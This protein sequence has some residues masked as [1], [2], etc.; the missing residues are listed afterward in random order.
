MGN[1][2]KLIAS[3]LKWARTNT[4]LSVAQIAKACDVDEQKYLTL[5]EGNDD[6]SFTFL[7]KAAL[8]LKMD[9]SELVS[10]DNPKL[11][12]FNVTRAGEG[13]PIKRREGFNYR[14]MAPLLKNRASEP[15][16]VTAKFQPD[17]QDMPIPLST[18]RGQ[19]FDMVIK[20]TLKVQLDDHIIVLRQGDTVYYDSSHR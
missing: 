11:S 7:Y 20:G 6:F 13:M 14:H 17:Q 16:I 3:R 15:F 4:D 5:E 18:H 1:Q 19:E 2:T 9:I 10:G 8:A 12:F